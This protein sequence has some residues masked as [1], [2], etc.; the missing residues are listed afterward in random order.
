MIKGIADHFRE[1]KAH[2][3]WVYHPSSKPYD[4]RERLLRHGMKDVEPIPGMARTLEELEEIPAVPGG[5]RY[6]KLKVKETQA[7]S[8]SL[9]HDARM[10][11]SGIRLSTIR[12]LSV[13][14]LENLVQKHICGRH[15]AKVSQSRRQVCTLSPRQQGSMP[16]PTSLGSK[17]RFSSCT[18]LDSSSRSSPPR[19]PS[20]GPAFETHGGEAISV[21]RIRHDCGIPI[22]RFR[23]G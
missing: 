5:T 8:I 9:P 4:L 22:V 1:R 10:S 13:S 19:I 21:H 6:A 15:G 12:S 18:H 7:P 3:M 2:F 16:S 20:G 17:T 11:Q 23:R 14:G